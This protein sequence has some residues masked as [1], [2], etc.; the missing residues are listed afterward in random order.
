MATT[1]QRKSVIRDFKRTVGIVD[2]QFATL[3]NLARRAV[4]FNL[5]AE[6]T[7]EEC[8]GEGV[9]KAALVAFLV[10]LQ[11]VQT[12]VDEVQPAFHGML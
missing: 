8:E 2:P 9:S 12:V 5:A 6:V 3:A 10:A 11:S 7:D 4:N 1:D